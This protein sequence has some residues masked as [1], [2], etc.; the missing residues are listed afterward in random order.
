MVFKIKKILTDRQLI[1]CKF[2]IFMAVVTLIFTLGTS[3][4]ASEKKNYET[5]DYQGLVDEFN[6]EKDADLK[7]E[8]LKNIAAYKDGFKVWDT[9]KF[10]RGRI[11]FFSSNEVIC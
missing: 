4:V 8:Y 2:S 1:K 9:Q 6:G 3:Q 7:A 10:E 11:V 5:S